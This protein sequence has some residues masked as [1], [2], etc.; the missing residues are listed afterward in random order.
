M[1]TIKPGLTGLGAI[2]AESIAQAAINN[3]QKQAGALIPTAF[4]SNLAKPTFGQFDWIGGQDNGINTGFHIGAND[5]KAGDVV[6]IVEP[7]G[8]YSGVHTIKYTG[9]D[10]GTYADSM[11]IIGLPKVAGENTSGTWQLVSRATTNTSNPYQAPTQPQ[12][13]APNTP[14]PN[15][16]KSSDISPTVIVGGLVGATLL[17]IIVIK[18]AQ[19]KK[20]K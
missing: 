7:S 15:D 13:Q 1:N 19:A 20:E 17:T 18:V 4:T 8:K 12:Q 14:L 3:L 6:R 5:L 10:N 11:I 9:A 2:S 16:D